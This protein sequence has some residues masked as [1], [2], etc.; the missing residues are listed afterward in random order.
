MPSDTVRAS[1]PGAADLR[2][3]VRRLAKDLLPPALVRAL[4]APAP[5]ADATT[6]EL[7]KLR[8]L[9]RYTPGAA[10]LLGGS[11]R[12]VDSLS[13]YYAFKQIFEREIY[14]FA[15]GAPSPRILDCG[16]NVGLATLY[17]KGLFPD[18]RVEAF[19][20]DESVFEALAVN[21][22]ALP[23]VVLHRAAVW[24]EAGEL[25]FAPEGA[26]A[27]RVA[28]P[29]GAEPSRLTTVPAVRLRDFL[30]GPVDMLKLDIEGAE[31]AVLRDCAGALGSVRLLFVE[32]HSYPDREQTA[33]EVLGILRSAG[34]RVSVESEIVARRPF[35]DPVLQDGNDMRLNIFAFRS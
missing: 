18:A 33:D 9:P 28:G 11:V 4:R 32:Y 13:F 29:G 31:T 34:F 30:A 24:S 21:C 35:V 25:S 20:P 26:D 1:V 5:P 23:G 8:E 2:G 17:W 19:E 10:R 12:Y 6:Q 7:E 3:G 22:S 16:A 15:S 27:G 14:R